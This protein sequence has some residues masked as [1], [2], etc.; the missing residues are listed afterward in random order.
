MPLHDTLPRGRAQSG[1][2]E[3]RW[4][5]APAETALKAELA[6]PAWRTMPLLVAYSP[7]PLTLTGV[8][9]RLGVPSRVRRSTPPAV[10]QY[11]WP[12]SAAPSSAGAVSQLG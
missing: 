1:R 12:V 3:V 2:D 6:S 5:V 8:Q 9:G 4:A 10:R 7:V 11:V